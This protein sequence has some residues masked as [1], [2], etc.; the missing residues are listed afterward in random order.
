MTGVQTCALPICQWTNPDGRFEIMQRL[1]NI[2]IYSRIVDVSEFI[3]AKFD[4]Q[5]LMPM[6]RRVANAIRRVDKKHIL[7]L[8]TTM[9]SNMGIR[10]HIEPLADES[11]KRDPLQAFAPHVYDL[12]TDTKD[13]A[14]ASPDRVNF[15]FQ[16]HNETAGRLRMPMLVGEWGAYG[17]HAS[18]LAA[19][20]AVTRQLEKYLCSDT[21]W[22]YA[23]G[24]GHSDHFQAINRP[25]PQKIAG[26]LISYR[27]DPAGKIF[28]C[29]WR[30]Q[31][32]ISAPT[33]I[34]FPAWFSFDKD[35][36]KMFPF[37]KG[38]QIDPLGADSKS[39]MMCI[40]SSG[41][42]IDRHLVVKMKNT[43]H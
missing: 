43:T 24:I 10:S 13:V 22:D 19:A 15:I 38:F 29:Q 35:A 42:S 2:D 41:K 33:T 25:Y 4:K 12:V 9:G 3:F 1:N 8:E 28:E 20:Q 36:V 34:Y 23:K 37:E 7:F 5:K 6:Y 21:Y 14:A 26:T 30:E 31:K 17:F 32:G 11:G 16:R 39:T 18:T 40:A 27:F